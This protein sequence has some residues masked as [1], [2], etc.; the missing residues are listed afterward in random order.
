MSVVKVRIVRVAVHHHL[1]AM[2]VAMRFA[3]RYRLVMLV[4]M[5]CVVYVPMVVVKR[6]MPMLVLM[7]LS[8]VQPYASAHQN[9]AGQKLNTKAIPKYQD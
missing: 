1:V 6:F 7:S 3:P 2:R 8:Q 9:C 4:L 5:V